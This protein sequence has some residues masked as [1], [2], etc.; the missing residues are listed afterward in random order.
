MYL[1]FSKL[2]RQGFTNSRT[3]ALKIQQNW[4]LPSEEFYYNSHFPD[5][6]S[7]VSLIYNYK[8]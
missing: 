2:Q 6:K 7:Y 8:V 1:F 5:D 4:T 3:S